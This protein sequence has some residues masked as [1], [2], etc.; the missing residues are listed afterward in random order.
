MALKLQ[1]VVG[2]WIPRELGEQQAVGHQVPKGKRKTGF[3][4][5]VKMG[6]EVREPRENPPGTKPKGAEPGLD[7]G[8]EPWSAQEPGAQSHGQTGD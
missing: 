8:R 4:Q 1:Q 7:V 5:G 6:L 3:G 2:H